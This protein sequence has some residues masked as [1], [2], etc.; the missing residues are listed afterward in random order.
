MQLS[1]EMQ[2]GNSSPYWLA[3]NWVM[4]LKRNN[5]TSNKGKL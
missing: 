1:I 3:N 2:I 4:V 5:L